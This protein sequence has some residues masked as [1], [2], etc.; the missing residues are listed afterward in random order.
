MQKAK[1]TEEKTFDYVGAYEHAIKDI[2]ETCGSREAANRMLDDIYK[3]YEKTDA[4]LK[5]MEKAYGKGTERFE[6]EKTLL[7]EKA[8]TE[9]NQSVEKHAPSTKEHIKEIILGA[10]LAIA[11]I[12]MPALYPASLLLTASSIIAI[13]GSYYVSFNVLRRWKALA[14]KSRITDLLGVVKPKRLKL[15]ALQEKVDIYSFLIISR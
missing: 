14:G 13:G 8:R 12:A 2:I 6:V 1:E 3:H 15:A 11:A 5:K 9:L 10:S 7:L 4:S